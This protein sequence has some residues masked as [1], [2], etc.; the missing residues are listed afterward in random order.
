[1]ANGTAAASKPGGKFE[2]GEVEVFGH[3]VGYASAGQGDDIL[4]ICPGSAGADGSWAKDMLAET[5]RIVELN[6]PAWGGTPPLRH[7]MDQRE[8]A[9]V[10]AAAIEALGIERFHVHGASMGG[11][12][13]M[14]IALQ[15]PQRV[16]SLSVEGGMNFV[17]EEH[18]VS[19]ENAKVL[20]EMVARG[21]PE[22][23]GYPRAA[24]HPRKPWADDDYIRGQMRKRI[25]MMRMLTN[26]HE[27]EAEIRLRRSKVPLLVLL[28][29][30][31][32]LVK[33]AHLDRWGAIRPDAR[34]ML[35]EGGAHDIQNTEPERFVAALR[36]F[37]GEAA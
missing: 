4:V 14:W 8:L 7:K 18:L 6:P 35:V 10:L 29:D 20:A 16:R 31:D 27:A 22:G 2:H 1:M 21:D 5:M 25:P 26:A 24:P 11:V 36:H 32:E 12:T 30:A 34:L 13:A 19:P 37:H 3:A 15:F 9:I 33:P 28:G 17:G 23:T